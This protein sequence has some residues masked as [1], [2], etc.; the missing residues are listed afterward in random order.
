VSAA[1]AHR[2]AQARLGLA[3]WRRARVRRQRIAGRSRCARGGCGGSVLA[4][5]GRWL[6]RRARARHLPRACAEKREIG[7]FGPVGRRIHR[8]SLPRPD[9]AESPHRRSDVKS[10]AAVVASRR[11][12]RGLARSRRCRR[13]RVRAAPQRSRT[14][15]RPCRDRSWLSDE[16]SCASGGI[17]VGS[18]RRAGARSC[19]TAPVDRRSF[20]RGSDS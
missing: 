5:F 17:R 6:G 16:S 3:C 7:H 10:R 14:E 2:V 13:R 12:R 8:V 4:P 20:T 11:G 19:P 15:S 18:R 1:V 9:P